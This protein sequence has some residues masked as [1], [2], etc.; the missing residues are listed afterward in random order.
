[1]KKKNT[2]KRRLKRDVKYYIL[3]I[4]FI[5]LI[6]FSSVKIV[7]WIIDNNKNKEALDESMKSFMIIEKDG[8]EEYKV[9]FK[10]LKKQNSD[11]VAWLKVNGTNINYP[12]VKTS[13]NDY[14]IYTNLNKEYSEAG[15]IFMDYKNV[16]D[17][18]DKNIVI[19]GH[20]R[21]DGS[22]FGSLKNT[23]NSN[24]Q[25]D[26]NNHIIHL[27]TENEDIEYQVFSTYKIEVEDYYITTDFYS[28]EDYDYF[29]SVIKERSN[30]DYGIELNTD[31]QILTL[32]TCDINNNYRIVLHA[33]RIV[34]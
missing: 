25:D 27:I 32:S 21:L 1:M 24:W 6:I 11:V 20:G 18:T 19:Y 8:K 23:L 30:Y 22:M 15:W 3:E 10:K 12:V 33:K 28:N 13:D 5:I 9:D 17:N 7:C 31:D 4:V 26:K 2:K 16:L 14:Y 29:L 34:K